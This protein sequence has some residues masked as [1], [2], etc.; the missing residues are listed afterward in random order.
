VPAGQDRNVVSMNLVVAGVNDHITEKLKWPE[1]PVESWLCVEWEKDPEEWMY[2]AALAFD[3]ALHNCNAPDHTDLGDKTVVYIKVFKESERPGLCKGTSL[4]PP[5]EDHYEVIANPMV[6]KV[7]AKPV[8]DSRNLLTPA[9]AGVVTTLV[10][11]F[12]AD[13]GA[14]IFEVPDTQPHSN[15]NVN[16]LKPHTFTLLSHIILF[17][18]ALFFVFHKVSMDLLKLATGFDAA[19]IASSCAICEFALLHE[20]IQNYGVAKKDLPFIDI[21]FYA[22]RSILTVAAHYCVSVMDAFKFKVW[23]KMGVLVPFVVCLS[24]FYLKQRFLMTWSD[25]R[26]CAFGECTTMQGVYLSALK[27]EIIFGIKL[28][29]PYLRGKTYAVLNFKAIDPE[30]ELYKR[31]R[32]SRISRRSQGSLRNDACNVSPNEHIHSGFTPGKG[33]ESMLAEMEEIRSELGTPTKLDSQ[34]DPD[35]EN[36]DEPLH[37]S[38]RTDTTVSY[39]CTAGYFER[40]TATN[41]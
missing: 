33:L 8:V 29:I 20:I 26:T 35:D 37:Q 38:P 28:L 1:I 24:T 12:L 3:S 4:P 16:V 32:L 14:S 41:L 40:S 10:G 6:K 22:T 17:S 2:N 30:R 23:G 19:V 15:K 21:V 31:K 5:G 39:P 34:A 25:R 9:L 11:I 18:S 13:P 27:N 7:S 36:Y